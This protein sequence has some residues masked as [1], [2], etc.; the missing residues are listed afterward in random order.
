MLRTIAVANAVT[1]PATSV[2]AVVRH[3]SQRRIT[4]SPSPAPSETLNF[5]AHSIEVI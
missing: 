5:Q 1:I 4:G 2:Q 3:Q